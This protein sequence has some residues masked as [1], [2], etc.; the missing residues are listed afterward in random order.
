MSS[1]PEQDLTRRT[2]DRGVVAIAARTTKVAS[3]GLWDWAEKRKIAAH[4]VIGITLWLTWDV[5]QWA[6][7]FADANV[8]RDSNSVGVIIGA[9]LTPWGLMQAAMFRF[10]IDLMKQNGGTT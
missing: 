2:A 1:E 8:T 3:T 4:A 7:G 5:I 10:Y 6:I 9:V